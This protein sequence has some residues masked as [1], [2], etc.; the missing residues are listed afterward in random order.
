MT[1]ATA[2]PP[3][4]HRAT[5]P[6]LP[7]VRWSWWMRVVST[8]APERADGVAEGDAAAAD[9]E[10]GL[11]DVEFLDVAED[12]GGEGLVDLEEV[13]VGH[14]SLALARRP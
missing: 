8:R 5:T 12:L 10:L 1:I 13:D 9:V 7:P 4:R 2:L 11:G 14:V 6:R 3:P